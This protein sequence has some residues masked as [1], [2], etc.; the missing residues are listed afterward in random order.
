MSSRS[1][2]LASTWSREIGVKLIC[3]TD[4]QK[5][6]G[7][8]WPFFMTTLVCRC[9]WMFTG[10]RL[11]LS[12]WI[13]ICDN[14]ILLTMWLDRMS[15]KYWRY[16][17]AL[18]MSWLPFTK[19]FRPLHRPIV[20]RHRRLITTSPRTYTRSDGFTTLFQFA[21]NASSISSGQVQ[22]LILLPA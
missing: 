2:T 8:G 6:R 3:S 16:S 5:Y 11:R 21:T 12:S 13:G 15:S 14:T 4:T 22:G 20:G 18:K 9:P 7:S 10:Q 17:C 19:T 1:F